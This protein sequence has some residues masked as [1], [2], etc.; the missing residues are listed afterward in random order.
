MDYDFMAGIEK[1]RGGALNTRPWKR[2]SKWTTKHILHS[3]YFFNYLS[4]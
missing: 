1:F 3:D 4:K 2:E